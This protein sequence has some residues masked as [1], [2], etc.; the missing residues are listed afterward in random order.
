MYTFPAHFHLLHN[1][2]PVAHYDNAFVSTQENPQLWSQLF[3]FHVKD[4]V[5]SP[6]RC[7]PRF[8]LCVLIMQSKGR[9]GD[10]NTP[11]AF[12]SPKSAVCTSWQEKLKDCESLSSTH[13]KNG[14]GK[15]SVSY[16]F[17]KKCHKVGSLKQLKCF[18]DLEAR[19]PKSKCMQN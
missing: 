18:T 12:R 1:N 11:Q 3:S 6:L 14:K 7:S 15:V 4:C 2:S 16:R 9:G 13:Q 10:I 17:F 5:T 19:S 8:F